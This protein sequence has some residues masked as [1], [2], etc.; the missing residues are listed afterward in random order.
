MNR[1]PSWFRQ[2]FPEQEK[3]LDFK[4]F[5]K[6]KHV[7]TVCQGAHCPNLTRCWQ[8]KVATFMILGD[9]CTRA[10]RFC[11]VTSGTPKAVDEKEPLAIA[12]AV[13]DAGLDYVVLTSV[14]RDDLK[15]QGV[16]QFCRTMSAIRSHREEACIEVLVP[17]LRADPLLIQKIIECAPQ[18]FGHNIETV[19]RLS[20]V[21]R[22]QADHHRSLKV[23][24]IAKDHAP[25]IF[26]KS[27]LMLGLGET[28]ADIM[29]AMR[30][31]LDHGCD[32]L[33][34]G[35]YLSPS[36]TSR[37][38]VVQRFVHPDDFQRYKDK[39]LALG[40]KGVVS[41]PLVRSSYMAKEM[42][43]A[44]CAKDLAAGRILI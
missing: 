29:E 27:G 40:F 4:A 6:S 15:D 36:R 24:R 19:K 11:A 8:Q 3:V 32:I 35:Q 39:A 17:D 31:L 12:D 38:I 14:T 10:C 26:V 20:P 21:F 37:H 23:L 25:G 28:D 1:L 2:P 34:L 16:D 13:R 30:E 22:P 9:V 33:T 18:V 42:Y 43:E 44:C 5:L 41:G 7:Y